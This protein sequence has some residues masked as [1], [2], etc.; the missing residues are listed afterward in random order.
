L[1]TTPPPG[2]A[3]GRPGPTR[4]GPRPAETTGGARRRDV[5]FA[6]AP[7]SEPRTAPRGR[8]EVPGD[9]RAF[10]LRWGDPRRAPSS[11]PLVPAGQEWASVADVYVTDVDVK[12]R[13]GGRRCR[14]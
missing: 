13:T 8:S 10:P 7:R 12:T 9:D 4:V 2:P 1:E 5:P 3:A 6:R 11:R 14:L